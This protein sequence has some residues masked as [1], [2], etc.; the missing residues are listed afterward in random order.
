[1][2]LVRYVAVLALL[3]GS[4][5]ITAPPAFAACNPGR[6]GTGAGFAGTQGSLAG[7]QGVHAYIEEYHPFV[8]TGSESM[9]WV[10][11]NVGGTKWSQIGWTQSPTSHRA[12]EQHTDASGHW[13]TNYWPDQGGTTNDYKVIQSA[14]GPGQTVWNFY[15]NGSLKLQPTR[16]WSASGYQL[17]GETHQKADQMAGGFSSFGTK[18][19]L[20]GG[21]KQNSAGTWS[22]VT[23]AAGANAAIYGAQLNSGTYYIW[24]TACAS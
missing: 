3:A 8:G 17:Y 23:T 4:T 22:A 5:L 9:M 16:V 10:M 1:M 21:Q 12:F 7:V 2:R 24:D 18:A 13:F 14:V 11:L 20:S 6:T 19:V 15:I